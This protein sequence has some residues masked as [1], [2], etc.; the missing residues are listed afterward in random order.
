M[1]AVSVFFIEP[2]DRERRSLRRYRSSEKAKCSASGYGYCNAEVPIGEGPA[3]S[4]SRS[5]STRSEALALDSRWPI[6]CACGYEFADDDQWQLFT[7]HIYRRPDTGEEMTLHDAPVGAC[8]N[9]FW[10]AEFR[11]ARPR[12]CFGIGDDGRSLVVKLPGNHDWMI[13]ERASNCTMPD[14]HTHKCWVRIGRPED[15]TLHVDKNGHTC[16]AGAGSI[17]VPGYHGF[18]HHGHLTDC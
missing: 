17:M 10:M 6:S 14:D 7:R 5:W 16:A 8:W 13:D 4:S 12:P 2:T 15:G 11:A 18:L 9:A 3:G 1:G